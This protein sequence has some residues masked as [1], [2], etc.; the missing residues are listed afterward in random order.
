MYV[1]QLEDRRR[2]VR[3]QAAS[4]VFSMFD[5]DKN[6][7]VSLYEISQTLVKYV[8]L[9]RTSLPK[10]AGI[11]VDEVQRIWEEVKSVYGKPKASEA[12]NPGQRR[13][14]QSR[15]RLQEQ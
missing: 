13:A 10:K 7:N 5:V 4:A 11:S 2:Y 9:D 12:Q 3:R 1:A 6:G 8:D 15:N 14:R